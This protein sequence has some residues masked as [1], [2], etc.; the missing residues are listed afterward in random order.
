M[1]DIKYIDKKKLLIDALKYKKTH[2]PSEYL[3]AN[4]FKIVNNTISASIIR[5]DTSTINYCRSKSYIYTLKSLNSYD[6]KFDIFSYMQTSSRQGI[7][8]ALFIL[9]QKIPQRII[10]INRIVKKLEY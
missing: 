3:I 4:I 8:S 7:S 2:I 9:K 10:K 5:T 1:Q 6:L